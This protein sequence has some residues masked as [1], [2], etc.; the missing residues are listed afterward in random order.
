MDEQPKDGGPTW[1]KL[2]QAIEQMVSYPVGEELHVSRSA[3]DKALDWIKW[4]EVYQSEPVPKLLSEEDEALSLVWR[5]ADGWAIRR[6]FPTDGG[7]YW[8]AMPSRATPTVL[9]ADPEVKALVEAAL[10]AEVARLRERERVLS[11]FIAEFAAAKID[12]LRHQP[13][14]GESPEDEPD[15]VVEAETVWAWQ[16]DAKDILSAAQSAGMAGE[17]V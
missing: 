6:T 10:A 16:A 14:Y 3:A 17:G 4:A 2:R 5:T 11:D 7:P 1:P 15:P 9:A 8:L 12:A 13:A